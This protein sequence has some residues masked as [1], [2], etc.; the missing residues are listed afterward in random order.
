[1]RR[2][3]RGELVYLGRL[4]AQVKV[5]GHRVELGAIESV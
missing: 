4:D 3:E 5:R 1:V 2:D